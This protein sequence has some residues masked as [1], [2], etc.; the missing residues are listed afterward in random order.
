MPIGG[1]RVR[2]RQAQPD[3]VVEVQSEELVERMTHGGK[4]GDR[5]SDP[6]APTSHAATAVDHEPNRC[7]CVFVR[8]ELNRARFVVVVDG[9]MVLT[10]TGDERALAIDDRDRQGD[11]IR[12]DGENRG[13]LVSLLWRCR[14]ADATGGDQQCQIRQCSHDDPRRGNGL[15][16][17]SRQTVRWLRQL[18]RRRRTP[19]P[20]PSSSE[21]NPPT[22]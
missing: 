12:A 18:Y 5:R 17:K 22:P 14:G 15:A 2:R 6:F 10:E 16:E 8:E 13:P 21:V 1:E 19:T 11:E 7:R 3:S 20:S 9:E 4:G